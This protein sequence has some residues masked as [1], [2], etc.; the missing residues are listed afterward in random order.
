M[1]R[2]AKKG[3]KGS[4]R[5]QGVILVLVVG[6]LTFVPFIPSNAVRLCILQSGHPIAAVFA[7]PSKLSKSAYKYYSG[8]K[9]Q[10]H[11]QINMPFSTESADIDVLVVHKIAKN[12]FY[13]K[14]VATPTYELG[15]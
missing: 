14:Y 6:L 4:F 11:Y 10:L 2:E 7:G 5:W 1:I 13:D 12:H 9:K 3:L 8:N 15:P